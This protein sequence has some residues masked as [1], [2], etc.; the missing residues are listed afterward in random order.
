MENNKENLLNQEMPRRE[1]IR[2]SLI[3]SGG[4]FIGADTISKLSLPELNA[5]MKPSKASSDKKDKDKDKDKDRPGTGGGRY[6]I[7][8]LEVVTD[9][10]N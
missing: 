7:N 2:K 4:V 10:D 6:G 1:F 3:A 9:E 5:A 8:R